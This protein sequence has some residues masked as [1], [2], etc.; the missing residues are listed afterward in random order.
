MTPEIES[1]PRPEWSPL[2]YEG[3]RNVQGKVLVDEKELL[4]AVLRFEPDGTIHEHP[5]ATD[6]VVV[7]LDGS[8][9]TSV[10]SETAPLH[11]GQRVRWPAGITHRLWT[12]D[13]TMTTLMVERPRHV[14]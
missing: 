7:C 5:G 14:P 6:T 12:E 9:F 3:C 1:V 13:S 4:L 10:A 8:G 2:P 11:A